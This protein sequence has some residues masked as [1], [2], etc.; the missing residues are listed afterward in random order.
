MAAFGSG[1]CTAATLLVSL[2][3]HPLL[4]RP[5]HNAGGADAPRE[6]NHHKTTCCSQLSSM[7]RSRGPAH[8]SRR[9]L[10]LRVVCSAPV[11]ISENVAGHISSRT[12]VS[13]PF[14]P[15]SI[16]HWHVSCN[17]LPPPLYHTSAMDYQKWRHFIVWGSGACVCGAG[18][19]ASRAQALVSSWWPRSTAGVVAIGVGS[20]SRPCST[21]TTAADSAGD[22][23]LLVWGVYFSVPSTYPVGA[24]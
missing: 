15:P 2:S 9:A 4:D 7:A 18:F 1:T 16:R 10:S 17:C 12:Q 3:N 11:E 14:L 20:G 19:A 22:W 23:E 5:Q 8:D 21:F 13:P 6:Q 24:S